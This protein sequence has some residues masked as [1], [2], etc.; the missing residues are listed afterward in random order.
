MGFVPKFDSPAR[1]SGA[2]PPQWRG[3]AAGLGGCLLVTLLGRSLAGES[4]PP[5]LLGSGA[6][7]VA[8]GARG[9]D[10]GGVNPGDER[11]LSWREEAGHTARAPASRG[12]G[13]A[14]RALG[15]GRA[16]ACWCAVTA[17]HSAH[18]SFLPRPASPRP[19][20]KPRAS[21]AAVRVTRRHP[22]R[23]RRRE[24]P[25]PHGQ[26]AAQ[27]P[28]LLGRGFPKPRPIQCLSLSHRMFWYS[29]C[30]FIFM[31]CFLVGS[32]RRRVGGAPSWS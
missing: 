17:H 5:R 25:K 30:F 12:P 29:L 7:A 2:A 3:A 20:R 27:P 15:T 21:H 18:P 16:H 28:R 6:P 32:S 1:E 8:R 14:P 26:G 19:T 24:L 9:T 4:Q 13:R 11:R 22:S 23:R 10:G 31:F